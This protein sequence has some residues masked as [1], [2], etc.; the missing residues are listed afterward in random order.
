MWPVSASASGQ[1]LRIAF[2]GQRTYFHACSWHEDSAAAVTCFID[3]RAGA[4]P[5]L[6][7]SRLDQFAPDVI[8]LFR[9]ETVP[10]GLLADM[11]AVVAGFLTEPISRRADGGASHWDLESRRK[12]LRA[13]DPRNID[14]VISFDP[15]IADVV[16]EE[17]MPVW[18]SQ[19]LPV[20]DYLFGEV[21]EPDG[22]PRM[23]FVGRST[24][25][26][27]TM[28]AAAKHRFDVLHV[29][30]GVREDEL[31]LLLP[32]YQVTFN[33]HNEPYPS[34]E[35]RVHIHM[36]AGHLVISETLSPRHGLEP[37]R[38]YIEVETA[39]QL[40][41]AAAAAHS[42]LGSL[43]SL[44]DAGRAQAELLR[45]STVWPQLVGDLLADVR[46]HG[47]PHRS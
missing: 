22:D 25:H 40:T 8:V 41:E 1:Q 34:F 14:R 21:S 28:L 9:P 17:L 6:L 24:F 45:A 30:F 15:L 11:P 7:R 38:D 19:P 33:V 32:R 18:R 47:S 2:V 37:G 43:R 44:R 26:R 5:A 35:N 46:E 36:A 13:A 4:D 10:P 16:A 23:L 20:A 12:D 42:G 39:E 29:A 31:A 27:E 3:H